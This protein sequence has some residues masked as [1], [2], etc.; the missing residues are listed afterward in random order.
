MRR[1][2]FQLIEMIY[3][4]GKHDVSVNAL[5][6]GNRLVVDRQ[7]GE[8]DAVSVDDIRDFGGLDYCNS[9]MSAGYDLSGMQDAE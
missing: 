8:K 4:D 5:T 2:E 6:D 7:S 3:G 9:I 1:P